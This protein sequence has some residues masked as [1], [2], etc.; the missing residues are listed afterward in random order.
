MDAKANVSP[1]MNVSIA[2]LAVGVVPLTPARLLCPCLITKVKL[3]MR[4]SS[5]FRRR[6]NAGGDAKEDSGS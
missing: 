6:M 5:L 1:L 2:L 4:S 3:K